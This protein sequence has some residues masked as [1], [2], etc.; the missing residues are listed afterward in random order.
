VVAA[1]SPYQTAQ[2]LAAAAKGRPGQLSIG[3][4]SNGSSEHIALTRWARLAEFEPNFRALA[5]FED[6]RV[7][8]FPNVPTLKELGW[9]VTTNSVVGLG[10]PKGMDP[11]VVKTLQAAFHRATQDPEFLKALA[12]AGQSVTYMDSASF[13]KLAEELFQQERRVIEEL[14]AAGVPLSN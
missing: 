7:K 3:A 12:V 10:G 8:Q 11:R 14:K 4:I 13:T 2:D 1:D 5:V 9:N 6:Q